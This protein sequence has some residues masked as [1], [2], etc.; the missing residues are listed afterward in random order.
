[1]DPRIRGGLEAQHN[2]KR[3]NFYD[4]FRINRGGHV[5]VGKRRLPGWSGSL[6]FYAFKCDKHGIVENYKQGHAQVLR[7]PECMKN[8]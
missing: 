4:R 3:L 6:M 1:M 8:G 7:C 5:A 2:V